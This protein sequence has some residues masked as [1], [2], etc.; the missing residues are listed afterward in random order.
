MKRNK[1]AFAFSE[2]DEIDGKLEVTVKSK[3]DQILY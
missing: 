2:L 1:R 3:F